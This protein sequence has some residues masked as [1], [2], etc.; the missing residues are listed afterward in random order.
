MDDRI[1]TDFDMSLGKC[2]SVLKQEPLGSSQNTQILE[3]YRDLDK[4]DLNQLIKANVMKYIP[5]LKFKEKK[6]KSIPK[7]PSKIEGQEASN[8][9]IEAPVY[10]GQVNQKGEPHGIGRF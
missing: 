2:Q 8:S 10:K 5:G 6:S 7:R 4:F 9:S 1:F 3:K